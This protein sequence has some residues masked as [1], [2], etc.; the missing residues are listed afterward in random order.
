MIIL[1]EFWEIYD[2]YSRRILLKSPLENDLQLLLYIL[3]KIVLNLTVWQIRAPIE[4]WF[5][6]HNG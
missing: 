2:L 6:T 3:K 1:P 5:E 4:L